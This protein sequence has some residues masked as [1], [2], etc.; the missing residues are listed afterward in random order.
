[1]EEIVQGL[2]REELELER[3]LKLFDEGME[4][5]HKAEHELIESEGR[6]KQ[7]LLDRRGRQRQV[8]IEV[9]EEEGGS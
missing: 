2:E 9:A 4:L 5:I 8:D 1:L 3:A 6:L 7:V